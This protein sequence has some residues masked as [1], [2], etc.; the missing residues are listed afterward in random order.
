MLTLAIDSGDGSEL[1]YDLTKEVVSI[2][3]SSHNDVVLRSPGVAPVHL[4]IRRTGESLTFFGQPRQIVL[5]NGEK[6]SRGVLKEGDRLRVGTATV[7]IVSSIE[8][9]ADQTKVE[10]VKKETPEA[11]VEPEAEPVDE[12]KARAEVVLYNEP[13]RLAETRRL[14]LE[15]FR[16]GP[17]SDLVASLQTFLG[18][19]FEGRRAL[20]AWLDQQG[21]L[22][23][24]VSSWSGSIPQLPPR[25]FSELANGDRVAMLRGSGPEA[26]IYP[27]VVGREDSRVY[28]LAETDEQNREED[29][30]LLAE[31]AA[32]VAVH[33]NR[34]EGSSALLGEWETDARQALEERLPGSSQAV[35]ELRERVLAA[36]RSSEPVLISGRAGSGRAYLASLI[37]SL[38]PTGKPWIRVLQVRGGDET[39]LQI[40]LFGSGTTVGARELAAR[41]GGGVVVV[42]AIE[43][44]SIDLQG[45]LAAVIGKDQGSGYGSK[46]R[47]IL[48][49]AE[50]C[51]ALVADGTVD[52]ELFGHAARNLIRIPALDERREDLPLVIVRMLESVGDEQGKEIRGIALETLDSLLGYSF[53]GQMSELLA[54]LRRLVSATP[55]G[56]LVRGSVRR[57]MVRSSEAAGAEVEGI[58]PAAVLGEDDLKVVIPA[59]E[60]LLI[61]RVLRRSLGNQSKAARELNL[62]RGALIAKIKEYEIPDYRSLRRSKR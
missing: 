33:W 7:I 26:M 54:E 62:S 16:A 8:D 42:R 19:V 48:T 10:A 38:R 36:A 13:K 47:W 44:M 17:H 35:G 50:N 46:V 37:A 30:I 25:T 14:L 18:K 32:M 51:E 60:R 53:E 1:R 11:P 45:E 41:A 27:V 23:P 40:E 52:Q 29:R 59:V 28:L 12:A 5:L 21:T 49:A 56:E 61:D 39:A 58:D 9:S 34:V 4:V 2:G 43:R 55:Q 3:A 6:R 31:I 15:V 57:S 20:L 22:Q 24:I